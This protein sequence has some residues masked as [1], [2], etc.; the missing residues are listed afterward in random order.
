MAG[1]LQAPEGS[2]I[3]LNWCCD[4]DWNNCGFLGP[5]LGICPP[6]HRTCFRQPAHNMTSIKSSQKSGLMRILKWNRNQSQNHGYWVA[7][8]EL[9]HQIIFTKYSLALMGQGNRV[10]FPFIVHCCFSARGGFSSW[11]GPG[12]SFSWS[13]I[14][15][16]SFPGKE[17]VDPTT[18]HQASAWL[19][20]GTFFCLSLLFPTS[21][22]KIQ[23]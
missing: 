10:L 23:E 5:T 19:L 4:L 3:G 14:P 12:P 22:P 6:V 18:D 13:H 2:G 8:S 7:L 16:Q 1:S 21:Y 17:T 11:N 9:Y 20:S 15:R